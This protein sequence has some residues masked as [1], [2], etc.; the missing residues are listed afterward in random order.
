MT[1]M[2]HNLARRGFSFTELLF[3]VVILGIGFIMIAA[4]FPVAIQQSKES[5]DQVIASEFARSL[6]VQIERAATS[7]MF[8]ATGYGAANQVG[9]LVPI[10]TSSGLP[11]GILAS[12]TTILA[13]LTAADGVNSKPWIDLHGFSINGSDP[14]YGAVVLYRRDGSPADLTGASWSPFVQLT[15]LVTQSRNRPL[16]A[17]DDAYAAD[18]N[19]M[20]NLQARPVTFSV[21]GGVTPSRLSINTASEAYAQCLGDGAFVVLASDVNSSA[22]A[23]ADRGLYNGRVFRVGGLVTLAPNQAVYELQPGFDFPPDAGPDRRPGNADDVA[24]LD[25]VT[26]FVVGRAWENGR[27]EGAVQDIAVY[28]TVIRVK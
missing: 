25:D 19:V 22:L 7:E 2:Q 4:I 26:G 16:Y 9:Q 18:G 6:T 23:P 24:Q 3:A 11:G 28:T 20:L 12:Q 1:A 10:R 5:T 21:D 17:R 27:A 13:R 14:R 8:P 15:V